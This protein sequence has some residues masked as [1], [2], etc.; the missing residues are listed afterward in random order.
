LIIFFSLWCLAIP[1]VVGIGHFLFGEYVEK[2]SSRSKRP[3]FDKTH[4]Q[5]LVT[6]CVWERFLR[7]EVPFPFL[8]RCG[9]I[10][11]CVWRSCPSNQICINYIFLFYFIL[12]GTWGCD[13]LGL[14]AYEDPIW[15]KQTKVKESRRQGHSWAQ[16]TRTTFEKYFQTWKAS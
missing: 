5:A 1:Q 3:C 10:K 6:I 13:Q 2:T 11:G 8:S 16:P 9:V 15:D 7:E 12:F 14:V 4:T